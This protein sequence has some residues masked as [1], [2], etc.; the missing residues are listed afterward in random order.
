MPRVVNVTEEDIRDGARLD[1]ECC[2]VA[3]ALERQFGL[4]WVYVDELKI[5][6]VVGNDG[7]EFGCYLNPPEVVEFIDAFDNERP[8]K[9]FSFTL[10][11]EPDEWEYP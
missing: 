4:G 8:V 2:P 11:D 1:T 3:L 10:P 9:P 7:P 5:D 6:G